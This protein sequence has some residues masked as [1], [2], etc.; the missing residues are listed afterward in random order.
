MTKI[1]GNTV[2]EVK[3]IQVIK[4][5]TKV[6]KSNFCDYLDAYSLVTGDMK[7]IVVG[8]N[9]NVSFKNVLHLQDV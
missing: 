3:I 7:I 4:F 5:E 8:A 9:T 6:I 1:M 2:N